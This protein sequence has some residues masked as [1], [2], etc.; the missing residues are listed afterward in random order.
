MDIKSTKHSSYNI[1]YHLVFCP[2]YRKKTLVGAVEVELKKILA[3][4]CVSQDWEIGALEV[5]P[6]HVHLF[7]SSPPTVAPTTIVAIIKSI[8]AISLFKIFPQLKGKSFWKSG[9]WSKGYYV[10]TAGTVSK[11]VIEKYIAEQKSK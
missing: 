11:G 1:W 7:L 10:G 5:M 4:I 9:L 8:T 6:D 3:E 2:K